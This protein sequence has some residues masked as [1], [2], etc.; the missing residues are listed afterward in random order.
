M[1]TSGNSSTRIVTPASNQLGFLCLPGEIRNR[2]YELALSSD[3]G[4]HL[5]AEPVIRNGIESKQ[6]MLY[7]KTE[8]EAETLKRRKLDGGP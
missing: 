1:N 6:L 5:R 3:E 8:E 4:T 2:I 7:T